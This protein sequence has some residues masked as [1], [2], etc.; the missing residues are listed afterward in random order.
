[1][2]FKFK[3][4]RLHVGLAIFWAVAFIPIAMFWPDSVLLVLFISCYANFVGHVSAYEASASAGVDDPTRVKLTVLA[5]AV[6]DLMEAVAKD[7]TNDTTREELEANIVELRQA[8]ELD[9]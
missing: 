5:K 2:K 8:V 9:D 1:M 4:P 6:A 3:S 7:S